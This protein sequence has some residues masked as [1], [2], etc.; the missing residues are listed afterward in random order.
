[1]GLSGARHGASF[2]TGRWYLPLRGKLGYLM[3]GMG[4]SSA[5]RH[6][7]PSL[8]RL[9]VSSALGIGGETSDLGRPYSPLEATLG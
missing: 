9:W 3:P 1:M 7:Y 5:L 2:A 4:Q 6:P 8:M